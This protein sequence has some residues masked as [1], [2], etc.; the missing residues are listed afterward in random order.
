V[1]Q[2]TTIRIDHEESDPYIKKLI[3]TLRDRGYSTTHPKG[4]AVTAGREK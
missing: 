1:T 3:K 4:L 2:R